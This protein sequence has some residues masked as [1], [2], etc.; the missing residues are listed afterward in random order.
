MNNSN[1]NIK[2]I[3]F[4]LWN[5]LIIGSNKEIITDWYSEATGSDTVLY[6]REKCMTIQENDP[7][8][9]IEKFLLLINDPY[10]F[11]ILLSI[12][13]DS[14]PLKETLL[15][16][17]KKRVASDYG[18][19]RWLPGSLEVLQAVK[20]KFIIVGVGNIWGYQRPHLE[21]NLKIK[22]YFNHVYLSSVFGL[23]KTDLIKKAMSDLKLKPEEILMVGDRYDSD[24]VPAI[25]MGMRALK[26]NPG[27]P[28]NPE[29]FLNDINRSIG[30]EQIEDNVKLKNNPP[31]KCLFII[32]PYYKM[33]GSHN[34]RIN[35]GITSLV[36]ICEQSGISACIYHA[37]S[38][39]VEEY[40]TR[41]QILLNSINF[42]DTLETHPVFKDLRA[43]VNN[44]APDIIVI[45]SGDTLN[46]FT[47]T[48]SWHLSLRV[49]KEARLARPNAYIISYGPESAEP[50]GDFNATIANEAEA[51][52]IDIL[53]NRPRGV[54]QVSAVSESILNSL[55]IFKKERF[56]HDLSLKGFDITYWRRGCL[57][58]CNFCRVAEIH[59][60]VE[61]FRSLDKFMED[62]EYRYEQL[63]LRNLYFVDPNFTSH[64]DKI[65]LFC[66]ELNKRFPD[67]RWRAE[68]R[69]DTLSEELIQL[70]K[71]AGCSYLK[72]GL[73]NVLGE[74]HQTPGK[75]VSLQGA[76]QKIKLLHDCGIK[77]VVYLMLGGYWYTGHDYEK[78]YNNTLELNADAYTISIM[79]PYVGISAGVT[80]EEWNKWG[81]IGS[82]LDIRL[83]DFWKIPVEIVRKFY[84]LELTKGR[85]DYKE[86]KFI[87]CSG[88]DMASR[89]QRSI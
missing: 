21:N 47:D 12:K 22:N 24:I 38:H 19:I 9:F 64:R 79:T 30:S 87:K 36:E 59:K 80:Q 77:C 62:I 43:F 14:S 81:F 84:N 34:N 55:P 65:T 11:R 82:H 39:T 61:R 37:D 56:G 85:E 5:S 31:K 58:K 83:I 7:D 89:H 41:Y 63:G 73:E 72:L 15:N 28:I 18:S 66:K 75:K 10:S 44:Y 40:P 35:L 6:D 60:G 16:S 25:E 29:Q 57:G 2:A 54:L 50:L 86:R 27:G 1:S 23:T 4:D 70:L 26:I 78:M 49:A 88:Y 48:G 13:E 17:F 42:Y 33:F 67:I 71:K 52:F 74:S 32:P 46:S 76:K 51:D 69:F 20:D 3:F 68:S 53:N 45:T 8:K